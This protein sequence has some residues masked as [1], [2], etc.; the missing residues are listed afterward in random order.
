MPVVL[1]PKETIPDPAMTIST[2]AVERAMLKLSVAN[3][4]GPGR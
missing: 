4:A 1:A 2:T 3:I